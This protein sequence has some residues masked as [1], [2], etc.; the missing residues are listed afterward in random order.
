MALGEIYLRFGFFKEDVDKSQEQNKSAFRRFFDRAI[1]PENLLFGAKFISYADN[2][3]IEKVFYQ[4]CILSVYKTEDSNIPHYGLTIEQ[5]QA[6][7]REMMIFLNELSEKGWKVKGASQTFNAIIDSL[8]K[9]DLLVFVEE[10][11]LRICVI[12]H[13]YIYTR[14]PIVVSTVEQ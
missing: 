2:H 5:A 8:V 9:S 12:G 11:D 3:V 13:P 14:E 1:A 7:R 6:T 4:G 10:G